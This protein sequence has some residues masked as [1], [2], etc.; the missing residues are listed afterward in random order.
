MSG[1]G[2][3]IFVIDDDEA[4]RESLADNLGLR[5][6]DVVTFSGAAAA[7]E[8]LDAGFTGVV[9]SDLRMPGMDGLALMRRLA[10]IDAQIPFVLISGHADVPTAIAAV[11]EGAYDFLTK[12]FNLDALVATL[13][14]A[15]DHRALVL[16]NR[17]L[18]L[19]RTGTESVV[20]LSQEMRL[21]LDQLMQAAQ[22]ELPCLIEGE[23]GSGLTTMARL[24][25]ARSRRAGKRLVVFDA[26]DRS[27]AISEPEIWGY[28]SGAFPGAQMPRTG[29]I[30]HA[31]GGTFL[32]EGAHRLPAGLRS[33]IEKVMA[34]GSYTPLGS[35]QS[36]AVDVRFVATVHPG[37]EHRSDPG[38]A[39]FLYKF[40]TIKLR[41]PSLAERKEDRLALFHLFFA[42]ALERGATGSIESLPPHVWQ[43]VLSSDWPGNLVQLRSYAQS[44]ANDPGLSAAPRSPSEADAEAEAEDFR[45]QMDQYERLVLE[46]ALRRHQGKVSQ[47]AASLNLPRKTMYDR[48]ARFKIKPNDYR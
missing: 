42:Q 32:I 20:A 30:E 4:V 29:L 26:G 9:V 18:R 40:A 2:S 28:V 25:H 33:G 34:D 16:A 13:R 47:A 38:E 36:R 21:F 39:G 44:L 12:P 1:E 6:Y 15:S 48:L 46:N 10:Q 17:E 23:P 19:A 27:D 41:V 43:E 7:L 22:S 14:R 24:L 8:R 35:N 37:W 5:G 3:L 11:R 31:N 45:S